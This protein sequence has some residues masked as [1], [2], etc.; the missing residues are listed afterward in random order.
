MKEPQTVGMY[1]GTN[2]MEVSGRED[3]PSDLGGCM[4]MRENLGYL[5]LCSSISK[6]EKSGSSSAGHAALSHF[7]RMCGNTSQC[8]LWSILRIRYNK[9]NGFIEVC[10]T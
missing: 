2:V 5:R 1:S 3:A 10:V 6:Q 8:T 4:G 7:V 9:G